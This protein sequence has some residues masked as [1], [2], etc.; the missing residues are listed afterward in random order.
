MDNVTT[1]TTNGVTQKG[2]VGFQVTPQ[3][4]YLLKSGS[5][6]NTDSTGFILNESDIAA[7][8]LTPGMRIHL[9]F[10][11]EPWADTLAYDRS[12]HQSV[13]IYVNGEFANACPYV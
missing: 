7:A 4:C 8:Y 13:N 11:I 6:V 1:T 12:Y 9:A 10:V 3:S 2:G 5:T